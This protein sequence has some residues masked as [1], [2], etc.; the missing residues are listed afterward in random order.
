MI[1]NTLIN[2]IALLESIKEV[3]YIPSISIS[4]MSCVDGING[5]NNQDTYEQRDIGVLLLGPRNTGKTRFVNKLLGVKETTYEPTT[6]LESIKVTNWNIWESGGNIQY[7]PILKN[8]FKIN[9]ADICLIFVNPDT[10]P[11]VFELY[12][13]ITNH[14]SNSGK[15]VII[16]TK[17]Q[18]FDA[19]SLEG[20]C[21]K[22]N[23]LN[24]KLDIDRDYNRV[25]NAVNCI[26]K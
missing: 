1:K 4:S 24:M 22:R 15:I 5:V 14:I 21:V 13:N 12:N 17:L 18:G 25:K 26:I 23:I 16:N 10:E 19:L 11:G 2:T 20:Y 7:L 8:Y 3:I 6:F 9:K